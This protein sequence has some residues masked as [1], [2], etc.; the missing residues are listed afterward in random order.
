MDFIFVL[1]LLLFCATQGYLYGY[2]KCCAACCVDPEGYLEEDRYQPEG[3]CLNCFP[4][5]K[6]PW[7]LVFCRCKEQPHADACT[8]ASCIGAV[9][10][11]NC[12]RNL[13]CDL[14]NAYTCGTIWINVNFC[15]MLIPLTVAVGLII[16]AFILWY[17]SC[18]GINVMTH[19]VC[20]LI[21]E[22]ADQIGIDMA[23]LPVCSGEGP[24]DAVTRQMPIAAALVGVGTFLL[25]M[26]QYQILGSMWK[27][28]YYSRAH[29]K[30]LTD[31]SIEIDE[32][33]KEHK[34]KWLGAHP[35]YAEEQGLLSRIDDKDDKDDKGEE[36]PKA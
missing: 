34:Q 2:C 24:C 15:L 33:A 11:R 1:T 32:R 20:E 22:H 9:K 36:D 21:G 28:Y 19:A 14:K 17:G 23:H 27:N 13:C 25:F 26:C 18:Y 4:H 3:P 30:N 8:R 31:L 6:A 16:A 5:C 35:G 29:L 10:C 7:D 12:C